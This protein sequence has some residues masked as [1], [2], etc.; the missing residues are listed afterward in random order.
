MTNK[1]VLLV[2]LS[3]FLVNSP[4]MAQGGRHFSAEL[5][6]AKGGPKQVETKATGLAT[7]ILTPDGHLTYEL[8]G[9]NL[10]NVYMAHLHLTEKEGYGHIIAWLY[11]PHHQEKALTATG[12]INGVFCKDTI[13]ADD[14]LD[15][16]AGKTIQDL[17]AAMEAGRVSVIIHTT[18]FRS[19]ELQGKIH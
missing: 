16:F 9:N 5:T 18:R 1:L 8:S 12:L 15:L 3:L 2:I 11:P 4:V 14:L 19:G 13:I 17:I 7:F 6:A 10:E